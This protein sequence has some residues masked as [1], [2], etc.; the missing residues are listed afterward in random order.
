MA[1]VVCLPTLQLGKF[2]T[3]CRR[4][5]IFLYSQLLQSISNLKMHYCFVELL[6][7]KVHLLN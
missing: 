1:Y 4:L 7:P 5:F 2:S 3:E 6:V